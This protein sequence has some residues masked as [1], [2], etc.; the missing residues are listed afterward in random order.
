MIDIKVN[1]NLTFVF[2]NNKKHIS[3]LSGASEEN[4]GQIIYGDWLIGQSAYN[5]QFLTAYHL[6]KDSVIESNIDITKELC[7]AGITFDKLYMFDTD[8][9]W[10]VV[11][12]IRNSRRPTWKYNEKGFRTMLKEQRR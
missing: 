12:N 11:K 3:S 4:I 8:T 5:N 7:K 10:Y 2:E 6:V 9:F 1:Y